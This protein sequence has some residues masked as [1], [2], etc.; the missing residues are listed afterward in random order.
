MFPATTNLVAHHKNE[1][2]PVYFRARKVY[3]PHKGW[4][5]RKQDKQNKKFEK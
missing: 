1:L 2:R 3:K 4:K 5:A